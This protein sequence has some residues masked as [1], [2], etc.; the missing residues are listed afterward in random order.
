MLVLVAA[1]NIVLSPGSVESVEF[2]SER[3]RLIGMR[4]SQSKYSA[5]VVAPVIPQR[6]DFADDAANQ[7]ALEP[8]RAFLIM[9]AVVKN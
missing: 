6:R 7:S 9:S 8:Q 5:A 3:L 1:S 4:L 2:P